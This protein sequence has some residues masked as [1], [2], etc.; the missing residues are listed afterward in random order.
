MPFPLRCNLQQTLTREVETAKEIC[1]RGAGKNSRGAAAQA[2]CDRNLILNPQQEIRQTLAFRLSDFAHSLPHEVGFIRRN[3]VGVQSA[4]L[5]SA[6]TA[7]DLQY[8]NH[9]VKLEGQ[10]D[11]V[12]TRS[13]V[14]RG[15]RHTDFCSL[16]RRARI[17]SDRQSGQILSSHP[18]FLCDSEIVGIL[19]ESSS[20][21]PLT[22]VEGRSGVPPR[23]PDG[24]D[25]PSAHGS[26]DF[27]TVS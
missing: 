18:S 1:G 10:A 5:Q 2:P 12:K 27:E 15:R 4:E 11:R 26:G 17:T 8:F 9:Q 20:R 23:K 21:V 6:R 19:L 25:S 13:Q 16:A 24:L 22:R 14:R 3:Q 7:I